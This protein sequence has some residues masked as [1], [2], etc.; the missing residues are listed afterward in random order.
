MIKSYQNKSNLGILLGLLLTYGAVFLFVTAG[1][2][3][4]TPEARMSFAMTVLLTRLLG[5][6]LFIWGCCMYAKGKGRSGWW[7]AF[8]LLSLIGLIVL[9]CLKDYAPK[10]QLAYQPGFEVMPPPQ[11]GQYPQQYPPQYPPQQ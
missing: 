10:G 2:R 8:G 7:G 9:V 3:P 6:A 1:W 4:A 11:P 5:A